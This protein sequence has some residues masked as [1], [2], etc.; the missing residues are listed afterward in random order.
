MEIKSNNELPPCEKFFNPELSLFKLIGFGI[1]E[2]AFIK[3]NDKI[4]VKIFEI[5]LIISGFMIMIVLVF[6][7][8]RTLNKYFFDDL[9]RT[10]EVIAMIFGS[11]IIITKVSFYY[12]YIYYLLLSN[13]Y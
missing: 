6:S 7:E 10:G 3:N 8:F 9:T 11:T 13:N 12:Q 5:L 2:R 1:L 4:Y